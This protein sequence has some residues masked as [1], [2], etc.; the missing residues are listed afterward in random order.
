MRTSFEF[1]FLEVTGISTGT[2]D[3]LKLSCLVMMAQSSLEKNYN[4]EQRAILGGHLI[5]SGSTFLKEKNVR[6][7]NITKYF[8]V[9]K[10]VSKQTGLRNFL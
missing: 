9:F 6:Y 7:Y 2:N 3:T 4:L 5:N 8:D 10:I 1:P